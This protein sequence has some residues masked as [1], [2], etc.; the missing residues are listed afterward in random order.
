MRSEDRRGKRE[1]YQRVVPDVKVVDKALVIG[2]LCEETEKQAILN[3]WRKRG[4]KTV[5][6]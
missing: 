4:I 6:E 1:K 5:Y 2:R 3:W